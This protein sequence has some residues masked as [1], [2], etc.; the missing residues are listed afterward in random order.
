MPSVMRIGIARNSYWMHR[1][2]H[3]PNIIS[4]SQ[5]ICFM[6]R[7]EEKIDP[8]TTVAADKC[9]AL[10]TVCRSATKNEISFALSFVVCQSIA[11]CYAISDTD[12]TQSGQTRPAQ[13]I[14][15]FQYT[16]FVI[17]FEFF[18][19]IRRSN[20]QFH[21]LSISFS[22]A[23]RLSVYVSVLPVHSHFHFHLHFLNLLFI[24]N[25][26]FN[27][28]HFLLLCTSSR[29][30]PMP[31][32]ANRR[33]PVCIWCDA[34]RYFCLVAIV[35]TLCECDCSWNMCIESNENNHLIYQRMNE[36]ERSTKRPTVCVQ[37][38]IG[39]P[40]DYF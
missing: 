9:V 22:I 34:I 31:F 19:S 15:S 1:L 14:N 32:I 30:L 7:E 8:Q 12:N 33:Q 29:A 28:H 13:L 26:F 3:S 4:I 24:T 37:W 25:I 18:V 17:I 40:V 27:N 6:S 10:S 36:T 23:L 35:A 11:S 5:H 39:E 16:M 2:R 38:S 21:S 20:F